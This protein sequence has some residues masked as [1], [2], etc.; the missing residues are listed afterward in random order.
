MFIWSPS[1]RA[2][3]RVAGWVGDRP[4]R[5]SR[6]RRRVACGGEAAPVLGGPD[7]ERA[8]ERAAHRLGVPKPHAA[9]DRRDRL[10]AVLQAP[11]RRL[12][13]HALD[14]ARRR[15][16]GLGA[17]RAAKWRGLMC[18]RAAIASTVCSPATSSSTARW[19]SRS[20]SRRGC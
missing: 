4:A 19:I 9:R 14:V 12:Q 20:G 15:D 7:A 1:A 8:Q 10:G 3:G 18:A 11:A 16:A 2:S 6:R 13:A 5:G 17:E